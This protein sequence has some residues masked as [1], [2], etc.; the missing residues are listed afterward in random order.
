MSTGWVE[1]K[2]TSKG[3]RVDSDSM[4]LLKHRDTEWLYR[5]RDMNPTRI[6]AEVD[7][8]LAQWGAVYSREGQACS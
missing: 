6:F 7:L 1:I 8:G 2:A 3:S 4:I 5:Y